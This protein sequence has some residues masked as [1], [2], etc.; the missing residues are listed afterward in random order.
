ME[1]GSANPS[2]T[3]R[4]RMAPDLPSFYWPK[5]HGAPEGTLTLDT[6]SEIWP[7]TFRSCSFSVAGIRAWLVAACCQIADRGRGV[8]PRLFYRPD[9]PADNGQ[10][11]PLDATVS[12]IEEAG[13][14]A[15][16]SFP[17]DKV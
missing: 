14:E 11:K 9:D 8:R 3:S 12:E 4:E 17:R 2:S 15:W 13:R 5:T 7:P 1:N 6:R 16:T 10:C